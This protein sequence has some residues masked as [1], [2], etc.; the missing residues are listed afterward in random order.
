M[1]SIPTQLQ[2]VSDALSKTVELEA[3]NKI[4]KLTIIEKDLLIDELNKNNSK[5]AEKDAIISENNL[6]IATKDSLLAKQEETLKKLNDIYCKKSDALSLENSQIKDI[7][8]KNYMSKLKSIINSEPDISLG[9]LTCLSELKK[10]IEKSK[11]DGFDD[12][13]S[14]SEFSTEIL[15]E[16]FHSKMVETKHFGALGRILLKAPDYVKKYIINH[17]DDE[18]K[19][20]KAGWKFV[21]NV[22]VKGDIGTVSYLVECGFNLEQE[23]GGGST[24]EIICNK[25]HSDVIQYLLPKLNPANLDKNKC[26]DNLKHNCGIKQ[27]DRDKIIL[28]LQ[29]L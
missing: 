12:L 1:N 7:R 26:I 27:E 24:G 23:C 20:D 8:W 15:M 18:N 28:L 22:C 14:Y 5:L 16:G 3:E 17:I 2:I 13:L 4:L 25:S 11:Y 19:E 6:L 9:K 10:I 21:H 29:N